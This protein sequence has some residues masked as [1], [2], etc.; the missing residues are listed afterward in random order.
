MN[1]E[2]PDTHH[3]HPH[4]ET[5]EIAEPIPM[6]D[7]D[8]PNEV[9]RPDIVLLLSKIAETEPGR[10]ADLLQS[11]IGFTGVPDRVVMP[12]GSRAY[13]WS[14]HSTPLLDAALAKAQ[15]QIRNAVQNRVN[16]HHNWSYADL[17][18]VW[19]ACRAACSDAEVSIVQSLWPKK[20]HVMVTTRLSHRGQWVESDLPVKAETQKGVNNK[21]ALGI[22]ITYGKRYMLTSMLGI[23]AGED[24]DGE[25]D[26]DGGGREGPEDIGKRWRE[27]VG[28]F[29]KLGIKPPQMLS[30]VGRATVA[31]LTHGDLA[32]LKTKYNEIVAERG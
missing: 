9:L 19:D 15:G 14:D 21:Q 12:A 10:A 5:T 11:L 6:S 1:E 2:R 8:E 28:A 3:D 24:T 30:M 16:E 29:D 27:A 4:E 31:E 26:R 20:T 18:A 17:A 23:P 22:A 7:D 13:R 25:E 32:K